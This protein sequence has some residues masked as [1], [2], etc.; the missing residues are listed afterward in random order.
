M[1]QTRDGT[2]LRHRP[3]GL[4]S[5]VLERLRRREGEDEA[6]A[7]E[8]A[9]V[10]RPGHVETEHGRLEAGNA[11]SEAE[12]GVGFPVAEEAVV[13]GRC[14]AVEEDRSARLEQLEPLVAEEHALLGVEDD[15]PR[16]AESE[17]RI[18]A[19]A[20]LAVGEELEIAIEVG[21]VVDA[22]TSDR[23]LRQDGLPAIDETGVGRDEGIAVVRVLA[24]GG[25]EACQKESAA[26]ECVSVRIVGAKAEDVRRR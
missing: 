13:G 22:E 1:S 6:A 3:N 21:A 18:R 9:V 20:V 14:A 17:V 16:A 15:A 4:R 8:R 19:E 26:A 5:P 7:A 11:E 23:G 10:E 12:A 24:R 2:Q 25:G